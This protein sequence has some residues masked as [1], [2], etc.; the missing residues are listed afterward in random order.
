ME[1]IDFHTHYIRRE[2][3][4]PTML[5]FVEAVNPEFYAKID[6]YG[7]DPELFTAYLRSQGIKHAVVLPEYAPAT[8]AFVPT[9]EVIEF[10]RGQDM[11][12]P[13]ASLNPNTHPD[14]ASTLESYVKDSGVKGLKLLPSY[15]FFYPNEARLYPLY[16]K[17][18]DLEIPVIFH[19]GSSIFKGTRL[20]Y[21]DPV[22]LD[23]IAVDFPDLNIIMAHSGRGFWYDACFFL[24]RFH[25]NVYMDITGLPPKKLL[26]Y[27]P[28][29][30]KNGEKVIFGSD[31]PAIPKGINENI[32]VIKALPL[33]DRTIEAML[34]G[35]AQKILFG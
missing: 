3:V 34:Y 24:S 17:A 8:S 11:L 35:N 32:E 16:A 30:D 2:I 22:Y 31:W 14:L 19:I 15:Q 20:K 4:N 6:D 12:I 25:K 10:C 27:F 7:N 9:E 33:S 29:L 13:F 21:C 18:R 26:E 23:D 1:I 28:E 5:H